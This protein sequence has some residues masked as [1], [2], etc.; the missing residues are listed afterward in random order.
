MANGFGGN[1][2]NMKYFEEFIK[3][4]PRNLNFLELDLGSND[5]GGNVEN[6]M[7]LVHS[8]KQLP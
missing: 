1:Q 2:D 8:M 6:M 4:L 7:Y 3:Y 5:I